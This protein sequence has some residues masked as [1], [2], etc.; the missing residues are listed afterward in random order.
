MLWTCTGNGSA[1]IYS[2]ADGSLLRKVRQQMAWCG[3][4]HKQHKQYSSSGTTAGGGHCMPNHV[5]L[6]YMLCRAGRCG[7]HWG[8]HGHGGIT[9]WQLSG[10]RGR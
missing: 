1:F 4:N 8:G 5:L 2:T 10:Q 7:A 9:S 6:R 3:L